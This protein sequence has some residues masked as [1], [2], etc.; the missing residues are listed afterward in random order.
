MLRLAAGN[1]T[2]AASG[3]GHLAGSS[4]DAYFV[5]TPEHL[6]RRLSPTPVPPRWLVVSPTLPR[7]L[8][9]RINSFELVS[10]SPTAYL[11]EADDDAASLAATLDSSSWVAPLFPQLKVSPSVHPTDAQ[12]VLVHLHAGSAASLARLWS[13]E[14]EISITP[15]GATAVLASNGSAAVVSWCAEQL[16]T[17]WIEPKPTFR[18]ASRRR[19]NDEAVDTMRWGAGATDLAAQAAWA[20]NGTGQLVAVGDTGLHTSSCFFDDDPS[21][22]YLAARTDVTTFTVDAS[23]HRKVLAHVAHCVGGDATDGHGHGTHVCGSIAGDARDADGAPMANGLEE[24][25][26]AA[27]AA[28]LFFHDLGVRGRERDGGGR[29]GPRH[30]RDPAAVRRGGARGGGEA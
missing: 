19:A 24:Y 20:L 14:L 3:L 25:N 6:R 5:P 22:Q 18:I 12:Q 11:V 1:V 30:R 28:R 21:V 15:Y 10:S 4:A 26:G 27:P 7:P 23:A 8:L 16:E 2:P 9:R 13:A 17:R 29:V